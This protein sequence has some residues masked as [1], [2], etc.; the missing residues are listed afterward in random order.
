MAFRVLI[1]T[2]RDKGKCPCPRCLVTFEDIPN[3]GEEDDEAIRTTQRRGPSTAH[4]QAVLDA[5]DLIYSDGYV[6]N[7]ERVEALL[8]KESHVPTKVCLQYG[9]GLGA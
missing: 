8:Q 6:V 9:L 5:R 3:L 7:S 4:S 2:V 1:A